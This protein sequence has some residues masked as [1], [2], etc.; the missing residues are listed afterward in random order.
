MARLFVAVWPPPSVVEDLDR[1][2]ARPPRPGLRW[3]PPQNWHVTL[4]FLGR[5]DPDQALAALDAVD[6]TATEAVIGPAVTTLG[7]GVLCLPVAGLDALADAVRAATASVGQ[8]PDPRPF[9]GHLTLARMRG[10]GASTG[11]G[12]R[13]TARFAVGEVVLVES[14][15]RAEGAVYRPLGSR[16]LT[17]QPG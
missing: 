8:P 17:P 5:C 6:A 13:F 2:L 12:A 3:V 10:R 9:T 15:T 16:P 1:R 14:D 7:R 11:T 4:R